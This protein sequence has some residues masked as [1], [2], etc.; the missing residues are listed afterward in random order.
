MRT[1]VMPPL[2]ELPATPEGLLNPAAAGAVA[3]LLALWLERYL[4]DWRWRPLLLLALSLALQG[5]GAYLAALPPTR[6]VAF[7][8]LWNGFLGAT[9]ATFGRETVYDLFGLLGAGPRSNEQLALKLRA[10]RWE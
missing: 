2:P 5:L 1:S 6:G 3:L 7:A 8:V 4:K 10:R 9:I